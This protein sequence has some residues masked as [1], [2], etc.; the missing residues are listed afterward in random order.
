MLETLFE[1]SNVQSMLTQWFDQQ[2]YVDTFATIFERLLR[3]MLLTK[4]QLRVAIEGIFLFEDV[5]FMIPF[6]ILSKAS[7]CA[8]RSL[9]A[10]HWGDWNGQPFK[11]RNAKQGDPQFHQF[12]YDQLLND[13]RHKLVVMRR[14]IDQCAVVFDEADVPR[15]LIPGIIDQILQSDAGLETFHHRHLLSLKRYA[16]EYKEP[17]CDVA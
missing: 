12:A 8:I 16:L 7:L 6:R 11:L 13:R 15:L 4:L 9:M 3:N 10:D 1:S 5:R 2:G 17:S 14:F